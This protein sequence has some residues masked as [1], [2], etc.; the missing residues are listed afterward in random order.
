MVMTLRLAAINC[1]VLQGSFLGPFYFCYINELNQAL[2]FYNVHQVVMP[3]LTILKPNQ[4]NQ[5]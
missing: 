2:K 5:C 4:T 1:G 3:D